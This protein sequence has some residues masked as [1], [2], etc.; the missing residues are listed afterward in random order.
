M[1]S[2]LE[3]REASMTT[4]DQIFSAIVKLAD[5]VGEIK[6]QVKMLVNQGGIQDDRHASLD[7]RVQRIEGK[8]RW[9]Q[10]VAAAVG[11]IGGLIGAGIEYILHGSSPHS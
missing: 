2:E 10:G 8:L 9:Y 1:R 6:G 4:P 5:D 3:P 7:G 11:A